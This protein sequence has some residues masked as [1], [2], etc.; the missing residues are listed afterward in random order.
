[1][2]NNSQGV[3][4]GKKVI[5]QAHLG[6]TSVEG[7]KLTKTRTISRKNSTQNKKGKCIY[8]DSNLKSPYSTMNIFTLWKCQKSIFT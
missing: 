2:I 3:E 5:F 1:M 6:R 8:S 7:E 4:R